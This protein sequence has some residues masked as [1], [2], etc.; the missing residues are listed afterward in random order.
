MKIYRVVL[1]SA[2]TLV[3]VSL[4]LL[5]DNAHAQEYV[6]QEDFEDGEAQGWTLEPGWEV[7]QD[8]GNYVLSGQGHVWARCGQI[9]T[10]TTACRSGSKSSA[11]MCISIF[12][13]TTAGDISLGSMRRTRN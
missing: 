7:I 1:S 2:V 9:Y 12:G 5:P 13:S 4:L 3:L 11:A 6:Y 8:E 10:M